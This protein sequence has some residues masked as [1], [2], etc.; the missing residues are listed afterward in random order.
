M[1]LWQLHI[2]C[3]VIEEKSFSKAGKNIHLSQPTVS[4]HIKDLENHFGCRLID[5][6]PAEAVPTKAGRLLYDY[7]H[8]LI[9][10]KDEAESALAEFQGTIK[11]RLLIGGSTIPG[12]YVLPQIIGAFHQEYPE[13]TVS[14]KIG[15]TEA[16]IGEVLSGRLELGV[17]GARIPDKRIFQEQ[18][19][20][21]KMRLI[22]PR[23]HRWAA[24]SRIHLK[25]LKKEPFIVR[26]TGSGTL[27]FIQKSLARAGY[28]IGDLNVV[29]E[30][31]NT[32]AVIQGIKS[33]VGVSVLS[34]LAVGEELEA[35]GLVALKIEGFRLD[36]HLYLTTHR[37]RTPSPVG[38]AFIRFIT[39]T[40]DASR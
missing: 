19:I 10:L 29:A 13:V 12:G 36:R 22:V 33:R 5:R 34:T 9:A 3:R 15:D 30:M 38:R 24:K 40:L 7:A 18:L 35:G 14:L 1:D 28:G 31:G 32:V 17:V 6:L 8:R 26:E 23:E 21:D 20:R 27:Q 11:G 2:F 39:E 4:S 16:I 25:M 37:Q